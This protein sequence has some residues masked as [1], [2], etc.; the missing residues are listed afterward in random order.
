MRKEVRIES[1]LTQTGEKPGEMDR[2]RGKG[3]CRPTNQ[4]RTPGAEQP[5]GR[6][7]QE[8][9]QNATTEMERQLEEASVNEREHR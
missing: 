9:K 5:Q 6:T 4:E 1:T 3:G 2:L 7:Q 8:E